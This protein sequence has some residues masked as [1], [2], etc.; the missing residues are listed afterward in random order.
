MASTYYDK[1]NII[2]H[3]FALILIY[4][5]SQTLFGEEV[6]Y[7]WL[8]FVFEPKGCFNF[9]VLLVYATVAI[10]YKYLRVSI[11]CLLQSFLVQMTFKNLV[12]SLFLFQNCN[13]LFVHGLWTQCFLPT[14]G[15]Q[16][17]FSLVFVHKRV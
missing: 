1:S 13:H 14:Q 9:I 11:E 6:N 17:V 7:G 5:L 4:K 15:D 3:L 12:L 8:V 16:L 2:F 10:D